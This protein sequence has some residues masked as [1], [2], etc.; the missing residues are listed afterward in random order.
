MSCLKKYIRS[1]RSLWGVQ[2]GW[3]TK[4]RLLL[5]LCPVAKSRSI[6][7][8]PMECSPPGS[9][10]HGNSQGRILVWVVIPFSRASSRA[11]D[12]THLSCIGMQI[13]YCWATREAPREDLV[14][15]KRPSDDGR[16]CHKRLCA[17]SIALCYCKPTEFSL[18]ERQL[19]S[20]QRILFH[21]QKTLPNFCLSFAKTF[22]FFFFCCGQW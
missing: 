17:V 2:V 10:V 22:F 3:G 11:R 18:D 19:P 16:L 21:F 9:S 13:L 15:G 8:N 7:C 20:T 6:L 5:L 4:R 1:E 14:T 12:Q